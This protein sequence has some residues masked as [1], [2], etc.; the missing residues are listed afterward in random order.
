MGDPADSGWSLASLDLEKIREL[1]TRTY[2][3]AGR[4]DWSH[5]YPYYH[6][7]IVFRDT[8]Q[9]V[10]GKGAFT[11]LCERL[12]RRSQG[13]RM[14]IHSL[15]RGQGS[16]H[17]EWTMTLAFRGAPSTPLHGSTVLSLGPDGRIL[18]QHDY[19]D[20]WGDIFDGIP[21][22][23]PAYRRFMRRLFG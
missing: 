13:L 2:N 18:R 1:W 21:F 3:Q 4:P 9:E 6:P 10:R 15:A 8:I 19:Y 14:E 23:K 16:I 22:F 11:A 20:L 7:D 5:L 12:A 17:I